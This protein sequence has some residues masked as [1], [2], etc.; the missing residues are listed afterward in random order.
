MAP[1]PR[2][3]LLPKE[4]FAFSFGKLKTQNYHDP[5]TRAP[6][7]HTIRTL[8][9]NPT[10]QLIATGS[11]DRTLRIWNPERP[12]VRYSTD[13]RGH[14]AG[15]EK[16]VFNPVRD[17]ELASCSTDGTVRIWDVRSKTCVSRL[18]IGG[19]PFTLSWSPDGTTIIA[20]R[21]DD[22]LVPISVTSPS[23]PN[24][25]SNGISTS[26]PTSKSNA[27]TYTALEPRPQ[28]VQTNATTFSHHVSTPSSPDLHFF[29]TTGDG[30]VKIISYPSFNV[31]HTLNAHTS[32]CSAVSL[33]PLGR[34]LAIGGSDALISLW[35]TTD[36]ICR[37][38]LSSENGG[39]IRNVSWSFDGRFICGA[40]DELG[41]GGHGLEIFHAES[42]DSVYTVPTSGN[43]NA[44]IPAVAWHPSR[45][46]LAYSTTADGPGSGLKIVGA[47]GGG[48]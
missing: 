8:A 33:S 46:W 27:S 19:E 6:G 10:G 42:G 7:T 43:I 47:A 20:G 36:W 18:D 37:R 4:L 22:I 31:L 11:V 24:L 3:D 41:C 26:P 17:A 25:L 40:W 30:T 28:T 13:L 9:W 48:L 23:T 12:N 44:G 16:V 29:A 32:A 21:K 1:A 2:R 14:T 38:T 15:V 39:A 45:Y 34:Y 35:D 5:A